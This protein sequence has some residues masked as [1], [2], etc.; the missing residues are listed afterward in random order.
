M[1]PLKQWNSDLWLATTPATEHLQEPIR[2]NLVRAA[3]LQYFSKVSTKAPED[4]DG[5]LLEEEQ[6]VGVCGHSRLS[7]DVEVVAVIA[8]IRYRR[9]RSVSQLHGFSSLWGHLCTYLFLCL[10]LFFPLP[11][12]M[13]NKARDMASGLAS[14]ATLFKNKR[15]SSDTSATANVWAQNL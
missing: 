7:S 2:S 10:P 11:F 13:S 4:G 6:G 8:V 3:S 1:W 9:W 5:L 12:S 14:M 15:D